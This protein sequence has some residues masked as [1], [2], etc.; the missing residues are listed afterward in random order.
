MRKLS[1]LF[2]ALFTLVALTVL[3]QPA[4]AAVPPPNES[5]DCAFGFSN[6]Q[7]TSTTVKVTVRISCDGLVSGL[8]HYLTVQRSGN[9]IGTP[10][11]KCNNGSGTLNFSCTITATFSDPSNNQKFEVLDE[12]IVYG[13]GY[14]GA[15][16]YPK[17][18]WTFTS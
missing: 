16:L 12:A 9:V 14:G 11:K 17:R 13:G 10:D 4:S 15:L 3:A 7:P 2:A 6:S 18:I 1:A 8:A 5:S